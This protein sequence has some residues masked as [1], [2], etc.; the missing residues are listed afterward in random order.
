LPKNT[1]VSVD[2]YGTLPSSATPTGSDTFHVAVSVSGTTA[3]SA[4]T[5]NA[6]ASGQTISASTASITAAQDPSTPVAAI[7]AGNQTKAVA[8]FKFTTTNDQ[9]TVSEIILSIPNNTTVQSV[10]LKD[11]GTT[12]ASMPGGASSTFSNLNIVIPAN[13]TKILTV[14]LTLVTVGIGAGTSGENVKVNLHSYKSAPSSTGSI[15]TTTHGINV[16]GNNLYVYK[17][18]PTI[19]NVAL[20]TGTLVN[21]TN[22]LS[23]FTVSSGGTGTIG[24]H[25]FVFTYASSTGVTLA[26]PTLWDADTNTQIV[27]TA[28]ILG[29]ASTITFYTDTEQQIS[30]AKT[31]VLKA[32]VGGAATDDY[33]NTSIAQP[34]SFV[35]PATAVSASSTAASFIWSDVSA[36]S[37]SFT[38]A[39]W[40]NDFLVKNLP[41]DSQALAY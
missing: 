34:S 12:L 24:W 7:T 15:S 18:I 22:T 13:S 38:T 16:A 10:I 19:T 41:T 5:V 25:R 37:H 6:W 40:N 14:E 28:V 39:D 11:G 30:G 4:T 33:L 26:S 9:H 36:Q 2:V 35:A 17:A 27:G 8:A 3:S 23:K 32:T 1:T 29:S 21:G 20:P 31:Y